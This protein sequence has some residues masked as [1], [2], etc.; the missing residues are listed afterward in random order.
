MNCEFQTPPPPH[1]DPHPE[2]GYNNDPL[3]VVFG[4]FPLKKY[5][6]LL[7]NKAEMIWKRHDFC[8]HQSSADF[9]VNN[10]FLEK[11]LS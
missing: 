3:L 5:H 11:P 7:K 2:G 9:L 6:C 8:P 4:S 1:P 10:N